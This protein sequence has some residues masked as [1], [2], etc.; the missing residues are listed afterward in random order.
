MKKN[1]VAVIGAG[2]VGATIAYNLCIKS[3]VN[4]I[5]LIDIN[6][7]KA[8]AECQDIE[9]GMP[10][11][12][13]VAMYAGGYEL[14]ADA[15]I[16]VLTAGAKQ[17]PDET[18]MALLDRNV[19][20]TGGI[21]SDVMRSGFAGI[22]LVVTNPVDVL[23]YFVQ[24]TSGLPESRVFGSGTVLD[25]SRLRTFL[26]RRCAVSAQNV[27]GYVLGEHG[28]TAFPAWSTVTIAGE[29]FD[30]FPQLRS[31]SAHLAGAPIS[32]TTLADI[33]AEALESVRSA[34]GTIIRGK[35]STFYAVAQAVAVIVESVLRDEHRILPVSHRRTFR[36][37]DRF[38][39]SYPA[40]VGSTGIESTLEYPLDREEQSR[41]AESV[42]FIGENCERF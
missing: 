18:R 31:K 39:F 21:V 6:T 25:T 17:R 11:G 26:A 22:V 16:V 23:T 24:R 4:E 27:H 10:L 12:R 13:P 9:Q 34:A 29:S 15:E 32:S 8:Q 40:I 33:K 38:A 41:L 2:S 20:I 35:G 36:G 28:S 3:T 5:A 1:K 14:C 7:E 30:R 42:A 37:E 19:E